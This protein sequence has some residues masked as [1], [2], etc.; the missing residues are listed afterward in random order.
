[1]ATG[2]GWWKVA[3]MSAPPA[4]ASSPAQPV[5]ALPLAVGVLAV[6][7]PAALVVWLASMAVLVLVPAVRR[8]H[9]AAAGAAT[10][11][12]TLA[13]GGPAGMLGRHFWLLATVGAA[14]A[15]TGVLQVT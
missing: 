10:L 4:R 11:A 7:A 15:R 14:Y 8:W 1:M 12:G 13:I 5:S 6:A 9:L 3:A 2:P